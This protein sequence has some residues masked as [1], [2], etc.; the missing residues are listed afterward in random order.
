MANDDARRRKTYG[1]PEDFSR[2]RHCTVQPTDE[3]H[4]L[5]DDLVFR[6]QIQGDEMFLIGIL[7]LLHNP[8]AGHLGRRNLP[9]FH[10]RG[11]A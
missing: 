2:M 5:L 8:L 4:F 11:I 10:L 1:L 9:E 3:N 7:Q 6:V